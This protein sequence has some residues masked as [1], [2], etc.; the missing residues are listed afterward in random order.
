MVVA[1][2]RVLQ[3]LNRGSR[4]LMLMLA[5]SELGLSTEIKLNRCPMFFVAFECRSW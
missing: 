5:M 1:T 3:S 2:F 4:D